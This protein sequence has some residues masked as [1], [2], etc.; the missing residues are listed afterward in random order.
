MQDLGEKITDVDYRLSELLDQAKEKGIQ[1]ES[2][3]ELHRKFD[4]I[5]KRLEASKNHRSKLESLLKTKSDIISHEKEQMRINIKNCELEIKNLYDSISHVHN[6]S[7]KVVEK[8]KTSPKITPNL[9]ADLDSILKSLEL[10]PFD[11]YSV[12]S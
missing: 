4:T 9:I 11:N 7:V 8:A 5:K 10:A 6:E 12:R 2:K 3:E 1:L